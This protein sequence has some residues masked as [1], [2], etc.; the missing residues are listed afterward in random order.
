MAGT[1]GVTSMVDNGD[2]TVTV[3]VFDPAPGVSPEALHAR[4]ARQS[5]AGL[6]AL[7]SPAAARPFAP[8]VCSKGTA[9]TLL[10]NPPAYWTLDSWGQPQLYYVD[11][12]GAGQTWDARGMAPVWDQINNLAVMY[13]NDCPSEVGVH[14]VYLESRNQGDNGTTG[15]FSYSYNSATHVFVAGTITFNNFYNPNNATARLNTVCH[16]MGHAVG[17]GHN[18]SSSSCMYSSNSSKTRPINSDITLAQ[19]VYDD[20][21][22]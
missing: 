20:V 7:D 8:T 16:E 5:V 9:T 3:T 4:L 11:H 10:C 2:G 15:L 18:T 19:S 12:G 21:T 13:S 14:C 6:Q 17:L 22:R 1:T